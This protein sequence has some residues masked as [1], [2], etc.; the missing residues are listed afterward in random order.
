MA[1]LTITNH[2]AGARANEYCLPG[3]QLCWDKDWGK[4]LQVYELQILCK[5]VSEHS[6]WSLSKSHWIFTNSWS[7]MKFAGG[8]IFHASSAGGCR[9]FCKPRSSGDSFESALLTN[10]SFAIDLQQAKEHTRAREQFSDTKVLR[11]R[12]W[13]YDVA[14]YWF[15]L[16]ARQLARCSIFMV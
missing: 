8:R 6:N 11:R 9:L 2:P 4:I 1:D 3:D 7:P 14:T 10:I 16:D 12:C 15:E 5:A 13:M